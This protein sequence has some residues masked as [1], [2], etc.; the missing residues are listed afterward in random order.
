[1]EGPVGLTL[2]A[3][4]TSFGIRSMVIENDPS[5]GTGSHAVCMSH[6]SQELLGWVGTD[7]LLVDMGLSWA[8]EAA[9]D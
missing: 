9:Q 8:S 7:K 3:L 4:L 6:R 1:V 2:A 5:Y